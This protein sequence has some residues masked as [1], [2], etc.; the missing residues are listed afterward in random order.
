MK[1]NKRVQKAHSEDYFGEYRDFW[2][3]LDFLKLRLQSLEL[4]NV[5]DVLDL[6]CGVGHWGQLLA[7]VLNNNFNLIGVDKEEVSIAKAK[8]RAIERNLNK[9]FQYQVG[10]VHSLPFPDNFFDLVTCQTLLIHL[11]DPKTVL[12]EMLRVTKTTGSVL[13]A[14]PNNFANSAVADSVTL[15]MTTDEIIDQIRFDLIL[16]K[17]KK[18]LNLGYNSEGDFLPGYLAEL[19]A[20]DI[21]VYLSDKTTPYFPPYETTE[22]KVNIQQMK[23]WSERGFLGWEKQDMKN[24]FVAG[25]GYH[26]DFEKLWNER[27]KRFRQIIKEVEA[28]T[29]HSAGGGIQY[30]IAAKKQQ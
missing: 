11:P 22:Q 3:S 1:N 12:K 10:D 4:E 30:L 8:E 13:L 2:W 26:E 18:A 25:G 19:G 15:K 6:G 7:G 20:K 27:Q 5:Q 17:G 29:Y 23:E 28:G 14:E 24:Y 9:R 21:K 16:Q